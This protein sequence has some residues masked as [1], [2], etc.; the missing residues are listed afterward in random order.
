MNIWFD[1]LCDINTYKYAHLVFGNKSDVMNKFVIEAK[2]LQSQ[3]SSKPCW[4]GGGLT[5]LD[6]IEVLCPNNHV[7]FCIVLLS[8]I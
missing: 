2:M 7:E 8:S 6:R 4:R 5:W 1:L 3:L